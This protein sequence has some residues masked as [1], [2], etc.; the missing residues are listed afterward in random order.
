MLNSVI[1][2][3]ER[4]RDIYHARILFIMIGVGYL[5]PFSALTQPIDYWHKIFP[6]FNIEFPLT[7]LYLWVNLIFLAFIVFVGM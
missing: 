5:F 1:A 6:T 7:T 4:D 3:K 2:Q